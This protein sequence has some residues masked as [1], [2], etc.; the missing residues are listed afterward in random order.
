M[1]SPS[2]SS[3]LP[4]VVAE[5]AKVLIQS[6]HLLGDT[7]VQGS[8]TSHMVPVEQAEGESPPAGGCCCDLLCVTPPPPVPSPSRPPCV[9]CCSAL[10]DSVK[11]CG[12]AALALLDDMKQKDSLATADDGGLRAAL[13]AIMATAEVSAGMLTHTH[14]HAKF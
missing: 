12:A 14:T 9:S 4:A 7:I 5:L 8:A 2:S 6:G 1:K 10:S 13:E 3:S 11:A